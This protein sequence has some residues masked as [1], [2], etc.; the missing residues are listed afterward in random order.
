MLIFRAISFSAILGLGLTACGAATS[1]TAH[2]VKPVKSVA[3]ATAPALSPVCVVLAPDIQHLA[4]VLGANLAAGTFS[5]TIYRSSRLAALDQKTAWLGDLTAGLAASMWAPPKSVATKQLESDLHATAAA[6][7]VTRNN[8]TATTLV[9]GLQT[10]ASD[11][12]VT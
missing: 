12:N 9:N 10:L 1:S 4:K 8:K 6:L 5:F 3:A 11:C 7:V 2:H